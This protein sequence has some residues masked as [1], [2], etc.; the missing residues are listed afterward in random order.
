[1]GK[2]AMEVSK[3]ILATFILSLQEKLKMDELIP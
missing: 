1:M 3:E 2:K